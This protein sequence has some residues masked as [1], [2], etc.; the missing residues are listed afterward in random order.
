MTFLIAGLALFLGIHSVAIAA[1]SLRA[2]AIAKLGAH[3]WRG[4]YSLIALAGFALIVVGYGEA[5]ISNPIWLYQP[6]Q[7]LRHLA[8]LLMLPVF[9]LLISVYLPGHIRLRTKHPMLLATKLWATAHLLANGGLHDVLLFGGFLAWAVAD[10]ISLKRRIVT[11]TMSTTAP[12]VWNDVFAVV[13][14]LVLYVVFVVYLH[15]L[16]IGVSPI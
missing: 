10:R 12:R 3:G 11:A 4:L 15:R 2:A 5:R 14:G 8:A 16:L 9:P 13:N 6:P 1:P 7:A